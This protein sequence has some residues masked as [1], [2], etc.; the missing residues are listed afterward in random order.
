MQWQ[1]CLTGLAIN[2]WLDVSF[3]A[4]TCEHVKDSDGVY[5]EVTTSCIWPKQLCPRSNGPYATEVTSC[6][7]CTV[8]RT[9]CSVVSNPQNVRFWTQCAMIA[10]IPQS[11]AYLHAWGWY[12]SRKVHHWHRWEWWEENVWD[13]IFTSSFYGLSCISPAELVTAARCAGCIILSACSLLWL[14]LGIFWTVAI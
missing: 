7:P 8:Q 14:W 13:L 10:W 6:R 3:T 5:S 2:S 11:H 1:M 12:F 9:E 4:S